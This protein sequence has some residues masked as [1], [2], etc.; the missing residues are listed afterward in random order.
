M[1]SLHSTTY[2]ENRDTL[3]AMFKE[4]RDEFGM[5]CGPSDLSIN[6]DFMLA[7]DEHN[8]GMYVIAKEND[9]I[10]GYMAGYSVLNVLHSNHGFALIQATYVVKTVNRIKVLKM[11]L[12]KYETIAKNNNIEYL[13]FGVNI[14]ANISGLLTRL[15]Y[16][17][18]DIICTKRI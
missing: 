2:T 8:L 1:I 18:S 9:S 10:I 11:M 3:T 12:K 14:N 7:M 16:G 13:Q 4:H 15:G 6:E 5:H 17:I